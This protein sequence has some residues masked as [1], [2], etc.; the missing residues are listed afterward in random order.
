MDRILMQGMSFYGFTGVLPF[1]KQNGQTFLVDVE[2]E[3]P[4]IPACE[5]DDLCDTVS[6]A[7]A[8]EIVRSIVENERFNLVERLCGVIC[9]RLLSA[10]DRIEGVTA[11]VRKPHAPIDGVFEAMGVRISRRRTPVEGAVSLE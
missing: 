8:Y 9:E 11:T 7:D 5:T 4:P 2:M 10:F 1:E 6:Y 3:L